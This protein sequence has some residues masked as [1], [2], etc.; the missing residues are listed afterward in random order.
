MGTATVKRP[1]NGY[2]EEKQELRRGRWAALRELGVARFPGAVGRV[3]NFT[4]AEAAA[5]LLSEELV[6]LQA[7]LVECNPDLPQR[8]VRHRALKEGKTL[9][10]ATPRLGAKRPFL[11]L[12]PRRIDA[13]DLWYASS[14]RGAFELGM[15]VTAAQMVPVDLVV[16]GCVAVTPDGAQL[17]KGGGFGDLEFAL[18]REMDKLT[19]RTPIVTTVHDAQVLEAGAIPMSPHDVPLTHVCTPEQVFPCVRTWRR[20]SGVLWRRLTSEM[21]REIPALKKARPLK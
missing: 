17:G 2:E 14:I 4:G 10:M 6:W 9:Y 20:P 11:K 8:P 15:P 13:K 5:R 3:P 16:L 1:A 21:R 12:D 18:L 7:K 19:P